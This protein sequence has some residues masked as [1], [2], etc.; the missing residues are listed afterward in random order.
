MIEPLHIDERL[1]ERERARIG[2]VLARW[3]KKLIPA[4]A[5]HGPPRARRSVESQLLQRP[6]FSSELW[7]EY[8]PPA[9][10]AA[11]LEIIRKELALPN[12]NFVPNDPVVLLM[13]SGYDKDDVYALMELEERYAVK[14]KDE[15]IERIRKEEWTLGQF[16]KDLLARRAGTTAGL[17]SSDAIETLTDSQ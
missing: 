16:V 4:L 5:Y 8:G 3:I 1:E 6:R 2:H 9:E 10:V 17:S 7:S 14:Y 13:G 15:E 11:I 12:H